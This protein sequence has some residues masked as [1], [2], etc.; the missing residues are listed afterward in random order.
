MLLRA[1]LCLRCVACCCGYWWLPHLS[2]PD[3][4]SVGYSQQTVRIYKC[5]WLDNCPGGVIVGQ[6]QGWVTR[7]AL[8]E[9]PFQWVSVSSC[10][11]EAH[12]RVILSLALM[13]TII[14]AGILVCS[15]VSISFGSRRFC[16]A[17]RM[18]G[19]WSPVLL[20]NDTLIRERLPVFVAVCHQQHAGSPDLQGCCELH[21]WMP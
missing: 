16:L 14:W 1:S 10:C 13:F 7:A 9:I 11:L 18:V 3:F 12:C 6:A 20:D 4:L 21:S 2:D 5:W 19:K 8:S 17:S 15:C